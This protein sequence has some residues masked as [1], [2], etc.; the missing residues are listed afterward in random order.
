LF[1]AKRG[2]YSG[3]VTD[4]PGYVEEAEGSTLFLDEI[5]ELE[6]QVQAKLL[7]VLESQEILPLG[8]ARPR[9]ID[10]ALCSATNKDLRALVSAGALRE[11]L[12]YRIGRPAV[13]LPALR[14]R[15]E[16]IPAIIAQQLAALTPAP[17]AHVSL[18]E[19][20]LLR[21]WPGNVREL[22]TE[23]R[24]AVHAALADGNRV[25]ARHLAPTAGSVLGSAMPEA[26][27]A[28]SDPG[29]LVPPAQEGSKRRA[30]R[31][32]E[33]WRQRI[34]AALRA[35]TGNVAATA[36]ALGLHR[37]QLRRMLERYGITVD[38]AGDRDEAEPA[39]DKDETER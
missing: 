7:R 17:A 22:I 19:Q 39:G 11:D 16:E 6:S 24:A 1:G 29:L 30:T 21:P 36:R 34:E 12:Y 15:P 38:P 20:C 26:R 25:E 28:P 9:K 18:V 2:A 13:M 27:S 35:H 4:A 23:L 14:N 3:A 5:A 10:F 37:T 31:D 32:D 8:A 33:E